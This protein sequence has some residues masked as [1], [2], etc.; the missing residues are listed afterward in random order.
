MPLNDDRDL[1]QRFRDGDQSALAE[2]FKRHSERLARCLRQGFAFR[3]GGK[4]HRFPGV[5]DR[6]D[7]HDLVAETFR[8][9]FEEKGRMAYS[10]T[11]PYDSYLMAIARNIVIDRL[12]SRESRNVQL[13]DEPISRT[14]ATGELRLSPEHAYQTAEVS[15]VIATFLDALSS[16]E[17][18][19][20]ALRFQQG[21]SQENTAQAMGRTRRWVRK[22]ESRIRRRLIRHLLATGYLP[23]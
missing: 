9:A 16:L 19:V 3:S 23:R 17:N 8:R 15:R 10:G 7:L 13:P 20:V 22:T 12:R 18:E 1:L 2:V 5:K 21:L 11:S 6:N 14:P 4:Q